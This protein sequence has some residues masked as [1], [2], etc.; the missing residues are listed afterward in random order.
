MGRFQYAFIPLDY[1]SPDIWAGNTNYGSGEFEGML[2]AYREFILERRED[3]YWYCTEMGTGGAS[4][5][6]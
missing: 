6:N 5:E 1:D 3:G 4:L 2:T